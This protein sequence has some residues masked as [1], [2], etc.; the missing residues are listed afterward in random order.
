MSFDLSFREQT[1]YSPPSISRLAYLA[2][3]GRHR[4]LVDNFHFPHKVHSQI[5][6]VWAWRR[7]RVVL[8]CASVPLSDSL[9][10]YDLH[11]TSVGWRREQHQ[12]G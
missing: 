4:E 11:V 7:T 10:A 3:H 12:D 6:L 8:A 1:T 5:L 9:A 2:R